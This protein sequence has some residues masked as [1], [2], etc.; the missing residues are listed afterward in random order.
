[1][2]EF[3]KFVDDLTKRFPVHVSIYYSKIMDWCIKVTKVGCA[4]DYPGS[5]RE[6]ADAILC[7]VQ[8][9]DI[10]LAFAKAQLMLKDWLLV[11]DGGY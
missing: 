11:F 7:D 2:A 5:R 1:M 4:S 9:C 6:G 3:L 8:S 10:E